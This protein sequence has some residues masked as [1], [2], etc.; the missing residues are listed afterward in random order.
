MPVAS[1]LVGGSSR[2]SSVIAAVRCRPLGM[3]AMLEAAWLH[4]EDVSGAATPRT[5][6]GA[7]TLRGEPGPPQLRWT[8]RIGEMARE[9]ESRCGEK[10]LC[11]SAMFKPTSCATGSTGSRSPS[12]PNRSSFWSTTA[13]TSS[14]CGRHPLHRSCRSQAYRALL[15][16]GGGGQRISRQLDAHGKG[17]LEGRRGHS[18]RAAQRPPGAYIAMSRLRSAVALTRTLAAGSLTPRSRGS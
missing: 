4:A 13:R 6:T 3:Q 14:R 12:A 15:D 16:R 10:A 11:T 8:L 1:G 9:L 18:D 17:S 7:G 2:P 5:A